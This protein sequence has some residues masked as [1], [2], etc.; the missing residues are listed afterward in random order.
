MEAK[1]VVQSGPIKD[2]SFRVRQAT[3]RSDGAVQ[4]A[5]LPNLD[6]VRV[7]IEYPFSF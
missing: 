3:L 5:D 1:Y 6:E 2:L 4:R 7:I